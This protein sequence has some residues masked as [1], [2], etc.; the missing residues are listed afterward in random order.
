M[1]RPL[2]LRIV[3]ATLAAGSISVF[4]LA[5]AGASIPT[6]SGSPRIVAH[7]DSLK[8]GATTKLVGTHFKPGSS[9]RIEECSRTNWVVVQNVCLTKNSMIVTTSASGRFTGSFTVRMC[10]KAK[11]I[12]AAGASRTCYIGE[13]TPQGIDVVSLL[14][15]ATL[16]VTRH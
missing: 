11:M 16:T 14:G 4:S 2:F 1:S 10:P 13:P 15:A 7:P 3:M 12:A 6:A 5:S 8:V 9:F